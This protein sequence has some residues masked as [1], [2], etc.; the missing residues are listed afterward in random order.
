MLADWEDKVTLSGLFDPTGPGLAVIESDCRG[1][2]PVLR[3]LHA[4]GTGEALTGLRSLIEE[5]PP[6]DLASVEIEVVTGRTVAVDTRLVTRLSRPN[7]ELLI[8][9]A[10]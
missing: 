6:I 7:A 2:E 3:A 1:S 10:E 5:T 8:R 9:R 4:Y